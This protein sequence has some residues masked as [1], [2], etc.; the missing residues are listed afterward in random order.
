H[1]RRAEELLRDADA[2]M[3]RAKA[4]GRQRF[5][6]FDERLRHQATTLLELENDLRRALTRNEF[7][8][9]FQPIV[10][11]ND[12]STVGYEALLRWR[13]PQRGLIGPDDFL[14]IAEDNGSAEHIDWQMFALVLQQAPALLKQGVFIS[15][16][17]S[18]RH[19]RSHQLEQRLLDLLAQY[20]VDPASIRV[21]VT[22]HAL[23]DNPPQV[24]RTLERLLA[25]GIQAS[26]DDF[27]TG[28]SSLSYLHQ[29]PLQSLKID[30]SFV[31]ALADNNEGSTPVVRAIQLL[32]DSLGMQVIA[33]GIETEAQRTA[34][35]A[36]HCPYGQGFLFG[37]P[38]PASHWL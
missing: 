38:A 15:I 1:Y 36:I 23:L 34:L 28:Y 32:A 7:E 8:P 13:H 19:F 24:K 18:G 35:A 27:G 2:A 11:I 31:A 37:R 9:W 22:E 26:L 29:Y 4:E 3:Y 25:H 6:V 5:A 14:Q 33:E 10:R 12:G 30:Q 16:N 20:Q 21:E 17:L